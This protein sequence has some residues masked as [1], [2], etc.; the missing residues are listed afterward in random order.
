M[1]Q[2]GTAMRMTIEAMGAA[3][4]GIG[5]DETGRPLFVPFALPGEVVEAEPGPVRGD[6][7]AAT[8]TA[9]ETPSPARVPPPCPHFGTCG[10]CAVQHW[11]DQAVAEWK[12]MRV[13]EALS[14]AG[15]RG[16]DVAPAIPS[17]RNTRRRAD[18]ALRR[19]ANGV[20]VGFHARGSAE[21][22][23]MAVC[24][25]IDPR[26][27]ALV[28]PIRRLM[29]SIPALRRTGSA[30]VNLL[31]TGP[32]LWLRT[33][34]PLTPA[35]RGKLATFATANGIPRIAWSKEG[36]RDT[37]EIAAQSGPSFVSLSGVA[38]PTTPGAF[39]QATPEGEAAI[40][41]AVLDGLPKRLPGKPRIIELHAGLGTL[42]FPLSGKG[43]VEAYEGSAEAVTALQTAAGRAGLR[44]KTTR[45]DLV[46]QP[47]LPAELKGAAA[48][49]L[50]PP[51]TGASE[52]VGILAR[53]SLPRVIYV[54]CNP[55]AL[56]RDLS[57]FA[58][59]PGWRVEK[60][61]AVDQFLWSS[62]V[63][64]VVTLARSP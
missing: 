50:D 21:P 10:A 38:V 51:F 12:A 57:A 39:L 59:A 11:A 36:T 64:A 60:A 52:Q 34:G 23:D 55:A 7:R 46:R 41:A 24:F 3:G 16:I 19:G 25:V 8:L 20:I 45:R 4:D 17:P 44:V 30:M 26:I 33:D 13:S 6:G 32:D 27:L 47:L 14:R 49:V 22:F 63:E 40:I 18:F 35:D 31:D 28:E 15:F 58:K 54:S 42:S 1:E 56:A 9:V 62:Q 61:V 5:R 2:R 37:P 53:S 43:R 48:L 29:A